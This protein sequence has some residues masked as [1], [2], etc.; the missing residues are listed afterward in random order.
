MVKGILKNIKKYIKNQKIIFTGPQKEVEKIYA[1]ADLFVFPTMYEPFGLVVLEA[2]AS[3]LPVIT[4][5]LSGAAELIINY[6]NGFVIDAPEQIDKIAEYISLLIEDKELYKKLSE[7]S[8]KYSIFI[9][10]GKTF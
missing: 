2:M 8:K 6:Q 4:T 10:N 9:H 5:K 3:G 7:E 1:A